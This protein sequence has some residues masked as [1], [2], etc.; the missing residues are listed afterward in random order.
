[1]SYLKHRKIFG[2]HRTKR[3]DGS[4]RLDAIPAA[5]KSCFTS[6]DVNPLLSPVCSSHLRSSQQ[7]AAAQ[8][9]LPDGP[10]SDERAVVD[11][12]CAE[13]DLRSVYRAADE[14]TSAGRSSQRLGVRRSGSSRFDDQ[15]AG[16]ATEDVERWR[17]AA[18]TSTTFA[19]AAAT[20]TAS[21]SATTVEAAT[22]AEW[23]ATTFTFRRS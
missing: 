1:M 11:D 8:Q 5:D 20:T 12:A 10:A 23:P 22:N 9:Q 21:P 3:S 6:F 7:P 13:T 2:Q 18:P 19:T 16:E 14:R 17:N 15:H 4:S